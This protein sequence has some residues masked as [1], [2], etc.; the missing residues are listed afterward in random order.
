MGGYKS[1]Q[2]I[3][4]VHFFLSVDELQTERHHQGPPG[5]MLCILKKPSSY[6]QIFRIIDSYLRNMNLNIIK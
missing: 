1:H 2:F 5:R 6:R 4:T 3:A